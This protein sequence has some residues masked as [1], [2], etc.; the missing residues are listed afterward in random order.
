MAEQIKR[1]GYWV[2]EDDSVVPETTLVEMGLDTREKQGAALGEGA[3]FHE[4]RFK[5][6]LGQHRM[7]IQ[8]RCLSAEMM[9]Y[10]PAKEPGVRFA[11]LV[12]GWDYPTRPTEE[13][14][15][16]LPASV[17]V[18][19]DNT[20]LSHMMPSA[21]GNKDFSQA[22]KSWQETSAKAAESAS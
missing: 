1:V 13:A 22:L 2:L 7:E 20:L 10:E 18:F 12:E 15:L 9:V 11:V 21:F 3:E 16:N 19:L 6:A 5:R 4:V 17:A 8:Q 14:Y